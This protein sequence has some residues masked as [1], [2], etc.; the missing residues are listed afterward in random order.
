[1]AKLEG[2]RDPKALKPWSQFFAAGLGGILS[3]S[4]SS[5]G[6]FINRADYIDMFLDFAFTH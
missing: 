1:M 4:A 6:Y 3:Q 2:H 5:L